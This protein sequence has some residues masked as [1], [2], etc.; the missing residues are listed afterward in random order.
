MFSIFF[1][2][3]HVTSACGSCDTLL[4]LY[5]H[6]C[7]YVADYLCAIVLLISYILVVFSLGFLSVLVQPRFHVTGTGAWE[8][9]PLNGRNPRISRW[10]QQYS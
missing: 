10:K 1:S 9:T 5:G 7:Q 8:K 6:R 4:L 2:F 3:C